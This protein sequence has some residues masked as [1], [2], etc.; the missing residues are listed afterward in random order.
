[1]KR[2]V[3]GWI[4]AAILCVIAATVGLWSGPLAAASTGLHTSGQSA[5]LA[6]THSNSSATTHP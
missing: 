6:A 4:A 1:M 2:H 3:G 5:H